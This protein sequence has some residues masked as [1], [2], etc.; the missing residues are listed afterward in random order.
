MKKCPF[1]AEK[2]QN[3]AIVCRYCGKDL[4]QAI[5]TEKIGNKSPIR[6]KKKFLHTGLIVLGIL[7][8]LLG[9]FFLIKRILKPAPV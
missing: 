2:I 4:P 3:E 7:I 8:V 5:K 9:V 1:C 6:D